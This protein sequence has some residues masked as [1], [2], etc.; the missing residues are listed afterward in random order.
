M[1]REITAIK[2][3]IERDNKTVEDTLHHKKNIKDLGEQIDRIIEE[4]GEYTLNQ[5]VQRVE[6]QII[7]FLEDSIGDLGIGTR[8]IV[9]DPEEGKDCYTIPIILNFESNYSNFK[10]IVSNIESG[11]WPLIIQDIKAD[12][13]QSDFINPSLDWHIE[14]FLRFLIFPQEKTSF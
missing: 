8:V 11:P 4:A 6:P 12:K 3:N 1:H 7:V 2:E 5:D 14:A 10:K 13:K 9:E